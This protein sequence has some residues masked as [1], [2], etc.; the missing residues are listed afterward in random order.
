LYSL[1]IKADKDAIVMEF[2]ITKLAKI[3]PFS[4]MSQNLKDL[5]KKKEDMWEFYLNRKLKMEKNYKCKYYNDVIYK[6]LRSDLTEDEKIEQ[7]NEAEKLIHKFNIQADTTLDSA[8]ECILKTENLIK[9]KIK[10]TERVISPK[11]NYIS[12][13]ANNYKE[14]AIKNEVFELT[15]TPFRKDGGRQSQ[16]NIK[17]SKSKLI[18]YKLNISNKHLATENKTTA[19]TNILMTDPSRVPSSVHSCYPSNNFIDYV[20]KSAQMK[21]KKANLNI[22]KRLKM[23]ID[24]WNS[25]KN[26]RYYDSG[27][28][29]IPLLCMTIK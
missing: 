3:I 18:E 21:N 14:N 11:K 1:L 7:E 9:K 26:S 10:N 20:R 23:T 19:S 16:T 15:K 25:T 29:D 6:N 22:D 28:Y 2:K 24:N 12:K 17:F 13:I 8:Y 5:K 27:N 4:E